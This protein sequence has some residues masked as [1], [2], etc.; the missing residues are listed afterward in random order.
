[1]ASAWP[2]VAAALAAQP[3][4]V[5]AD[6]GRLDAGPGQ[7]YAVLSAARTVSIVL[8]PTLRQ[9]WSAQPRVQMISQLLGDS[10]RLTLLLTGPGTYTAHEIAH[11]LGVP[12]VAVLAA[13]SRTARLLSDGVRG[14]RQ[15]GDGPLMRSARA[16]GQAL[17]AHVTV[18]SRQRSEAD[19]V[20]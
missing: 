8:R 17:R 20:L 6:C 13:D 11:A 18:M 4:D 15:F 3:A 14:P 16:A 2:A 5:I 1:M 9:A 7:P 19:V 10:S 12:V